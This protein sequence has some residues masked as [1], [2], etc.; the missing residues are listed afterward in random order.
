MSLN[1]VPAFIFLVSLAGAL[2]GLVL[3]SRRWLAGR[4]APSEGLR[5]LLRIPR[6]Y[7]VNV[8]EAVYRDPVGGP[9]RGDTGSQNAI[10]HILTAGGLTVAT[11]LILLL[12]VLGLGGAVAAALLLAALAVMA[13]GAVLVTLRR[14]PHRHS[15]RLSQGGFNH[16]PAALLA[17]IVFFAVVTLP[18]TGAI[19][20]IPWSQWEGWILALV[21]LFGN[22]ELYAGMGFGP[23]KHAPIGALHLAFHERPAR[24]DNPAAETALRPLDLATEPLGANRIQDFQWNQLLGFDSCVECGRCEAACP[25]FEAGQPLNPKKLIQDLVMAQSGAASQRSYTGQ[26][27]PGISGINRH[28]APDHPL[29]GLSEEAAIHPDTLWACTTCQACVYECPMMIEHVDAVV[30]LRRYQTLEEGATPGKG[31]Q[32]LE[33]LRGSDNL[34]GRPPERRMDWATDLNLPRLRD[35]GS[36][37]V[38]L[39]IGEGA[40]EMRNQQTLRALVQLLHKAEVEFATLGEEELDCGHVA[41]VLGDEALFQDLRHR[42]LQTLAQ[43]RFQRIVTAD[44][45]VLHT[46]RNEYPE[47]SDGCPVEHHSAFL[48]R[49]IEQGRLNPNPEEGPSAVTFHDP[50]YLARANRETQAPRDMLNTLGIEVREMAKSGERTSCCGWGGGASFTDVPGERRIPDVRMDHARATEAETVGVACPNCAVMLEGVVGPGPEVKDLAELLL[51]GVE[52]SA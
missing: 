11:L 21:G 44:P 45:H 31:S 33:D 51:E 3:R 22:L 43:Y 30:E 7:L 46:L 26:P 18:E 14:L 15:P 38:L 27:H 49:L 32:V 1:W 23:M 2:L 39:W 25:A 42:N 17:F 13:G 41:R 35:R 47:L 29:I 4:P 24:F 52:G 19:A 50:C 10:L 5:G 20:P 8:H 12:H 16:L 37:E 9:K 40:Y 28:S 6:R 36:C 34:S 48:T